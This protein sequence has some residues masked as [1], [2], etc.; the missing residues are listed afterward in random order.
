MDLVAYQTKKSAIRFWDDIRRAG[1]NPN[2]FNQQ[3]FHA[4]KVQEIEK[5]S[6]DYVYNMFKR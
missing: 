6:L 4:W 3:W 5:L 2:E 1:I